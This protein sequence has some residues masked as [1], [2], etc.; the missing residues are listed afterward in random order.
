MVDRA[1]MSQPRPSPAALGYRPPGEWELNAACWSAWP[2]DAEAWSGF[3]EPAQREFVGFCRALLSEPGAERLDLLVPDG[4]GE[5]AARTALGSSVQHVRFYQ[6]PYGDIWLRDTTPLFVRKGAALAAVRFAFNGWGGKYLYPGDVELSGVLA[7]RLE[8]PEFVYDTVLEGG[9]VEFDGQGTC[10][11]TESCML[12]PNRGPAQ[13]RAGIEAL[14]NEAFGVT[15]LIWLRDGL[16]GDHTDGHVDNIARFVA[17]GTVVHTVARDASD[18][19]AAT[20]AAVEA[21][22]SAATDAAGRSLRLIG[23]PSPGRVLD[24][25]GTF[26]PASHLNFYIGNTVVVVPAFG[27]QS[28]EPARQAIAAAFPDRSVALS[29]A[30]T[31]LEWGGGTFHCMTRQE[32]RTLVQPPP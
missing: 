26:L 18:P 17:P 21:E 4:A 3:L 1:A 5:R 24:A 16:S 12:N 31:I 32:P 25:N 19:N 10:L 14:F 27:G 20:Y 6:I 15:K 11:T 22:L 29:R 28:D 9:A 23:V 7:R 2:Y 13:T 8:L 30:R